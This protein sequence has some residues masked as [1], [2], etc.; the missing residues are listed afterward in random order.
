[1]SG[2]ATI[3]IEVALARRVDHFLRQRRWRIVA[4]PPPGAPLRIEVV[5]ERLFV[6]AGLPMSRFITV[7]GPEPRAVRRE[8]FINQYN[9]LGPVSPS[10][11]HTAEL[12]LRVG[13]DDPALRGNP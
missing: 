11:G 8:H 5:A 12:E 9:L 13:D 7:R 10:G 1:M 2:Q 4:V 6:E 3:D